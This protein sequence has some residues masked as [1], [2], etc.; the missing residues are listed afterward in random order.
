[1][2]QQLGDEP[3]R[4][5]GHT[6]ERLEKLATQLVTE[7][8]SLDPRA[9][10]PGRAGAA[11]ICTASCAAK[12][13]AC[14]PHEIANLLQGLNGRF[15]PAGPS[16]APSRGRPDVLPTGRNFYS[17]DTRAV[18]TPTAYAMGARPPSA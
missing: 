2:L 7:A 12:L 1:V 11:R 5:A 6:R 3:W 17:V 15:V 4:H 13:D 14:G 8:P 9:W 10:P 16:G 18:P